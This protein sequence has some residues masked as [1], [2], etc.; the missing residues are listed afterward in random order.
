MSNFWSESSHFSLEDL[1][2]AVGPGVISGYLC[3]RKSKNDGFNC[4]FLRNNLQ[5]NY[6]KNIKICKVQVMDSHKF[7]LL[8][9]AFFGV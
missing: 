6:G 5:S 1:V 9:S 3:M 7:I 4:I 8:F 2:L